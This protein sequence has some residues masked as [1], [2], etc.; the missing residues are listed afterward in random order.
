METKAAMAQEAVPAAAQPARTPAM[1]NNQMPVCIIV[2]VVV[3]IVLLAAVI[4][5]RVKMKR[6]RP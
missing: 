4:Y 6:R 3:V 5:I 1:S 2:A